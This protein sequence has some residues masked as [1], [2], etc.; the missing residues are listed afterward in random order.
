MT[1]NG[2]DDAR[3]RLHRALAEGFTSLAREQRLASMSD[4]DLLHAH[5]LLTDPSIVNV[6]GLEALKVELR[7]RGLLDGEAPGKA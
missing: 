7:R 1:V 4:A 3:M 6:P 5:D 2:D